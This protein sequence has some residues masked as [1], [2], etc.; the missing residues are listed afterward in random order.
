MYLIALEHSTLITLTNHG[1]RYVMESK[2]NEIKSP[3]CIIFIP[4]PFLLY[5]DKTIFICWG[6]YT[7]Q[8]YKYMLRIS[9]FMLSMS[10]KKD[11]AVTPNANSL[12][13]FFFNHSFS[14][15]KRQKVLYKSY[16]HNVVYRDNQFVPLLMILFY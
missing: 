7:Q 16:F 15:D 11:S 13:S 3:V 1:C 5:L 6:K 10:S 9:F 2:L 14:M 12:R 8:I 4:I